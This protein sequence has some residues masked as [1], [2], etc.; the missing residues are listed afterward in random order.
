MYLSVPL[1]LLSA[2]FWEDSLRSFYSLLD[3]S[4]TTFLFLFGIWSVTDEYFCDSNGIYTKI[5]FTL[6]AIFVILLLLSYGL[7]IHIPKE[8]WSVVDIITGGFLLFYYI[9]RKID[10]RKECNK[11]A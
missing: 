6:T 1:L 3:I 2:P 9:E 10:H 4:V 5:F 11:V 7:H 8:L